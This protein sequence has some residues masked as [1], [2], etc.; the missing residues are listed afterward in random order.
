MALA[1]IVEG[2]AS[3][4]ILIC[5]ALYELAKNPVIVKKAQEEVDAVYERFN[6]RMTEEGI[7]DLKYVEQ[8]LHETMRLHSA[9]VRL[10]KVSTKDYTFP[11]QFPGSNN[12]LAIP[13]GTTIIIPI[14]AIHYDPV[15]YPDPYTFDPTRFSEASRKER[16]KYSFLAFG[17][18]AR[19]CLGQK[20]ALFQVKVAMAALIRNFNISLNKKTHD[21]LVLFKK[22]FVL[23][24]EGSIW[25]NFEKRKS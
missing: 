1:F 14:N 8:I 6:G 21:P 3:S 11:P 20:F 15:Y 9:I 16:H 7:M 12:H 19:I 10:A 5:F 17:E 13:K 2:R 4:S 25:I 24:A 22:T 18:G 23:A